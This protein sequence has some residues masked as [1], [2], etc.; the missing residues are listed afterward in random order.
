MR[1]NPRRVGGGEP[2]DDPRHPPREALTHPLARR[3]SRRNPHSP[4]DR[5]QV[6]RLA[7]LRGEE[8]K[9]E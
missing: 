6:A 7:Q 5:E 8:I 9:G 3:I 4:R 2:G 1:T